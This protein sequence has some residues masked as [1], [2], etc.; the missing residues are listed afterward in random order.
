MENT[1][2]FYL[3]LTRPSFRAIQCNEM[4]ENPAPEGR[5]I[6][7]QRFRVCVRTRFRGTGW[8]EMLENPAPEGRANLAQ[9]F[10]AG[11][12]KKMIQV[13]EG[14]PSFHNT[15]VV[16]FNFG[17]C[18]IHQCVVTP[19]ATDCKRSTSSFHSKHCKHKL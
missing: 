9:R 1:T 5:P 3:V 15:P 2:N 12:V 6:L 13:P 17:R 14:R 11:E 7:A 18:E 8:N 10:S 4:L 19:Q 16:F